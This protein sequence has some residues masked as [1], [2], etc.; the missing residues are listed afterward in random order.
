MKTQNIECK[1]KVTKLFCNAMYNVK[2]DNVDKEAICYVSGKMSKNFIK[3]DVGDAV[4]VEFSP[5]DLSKGRIIK[6]F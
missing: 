6:R 3:P 5:T 2:L 1:G 4:L